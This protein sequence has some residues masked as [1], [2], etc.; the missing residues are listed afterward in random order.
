[1]IYLK[2]L[3]KTCNQ[4]MIRI[5][6]VLYLLFLISCS[7]EI[8]NGE[9]IYNERDRAE[10]FNFPYLLFIPDDM[11]PENELVLI[12]EPNNSGF[13]SDDFK[14]HLEKAERTASRDF[15]IGNY[16]A[17]KLKY[18]LLVPVFPRPETDWKIYTHAYDRDLA[19]QK[20]NE[21]ERLDLQ[22]LAMID[23]AKEKLSEK[24]Y[25][26]NEK[27]MMTGF[28]ASGTFVNRFS[29]IHP[30]RV[31][32]YAAGGINGLVILPL[33]ELDGEVLP[34]P[35]GVHDFQPLFGKPFNAAD[36]KN[37]PQFIFMGENDDND[38]I[39]F[40][41]G[42]EEYERQLIFRLLGEKM[43]PDRWQNCREIYSKENVAAE[44]ITVMDMGHEQPEFIKNE[45]VDFFRIRIMKS[46][47]NN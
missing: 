16:V 1:M 45:I 6:I 32:A 21:L 17:R 41:D 10:G 11:Q 9:L 23:H 43:Q 15:Y 35:V 12:V 44:I 7:S 26:I 5:P 34:F 30:E 22:L 18:P 36:F 40:N 47:N 37:T 42:Y 4:Y 24:G 20:G 2:K 27:F 31:F 8:K 25:T 39:L 33:E 3:L 29:A 38:A 13:A 19:L 28:S 46:Q 14:R